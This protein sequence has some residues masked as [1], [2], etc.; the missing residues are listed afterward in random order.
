MTDLDIVVAATGCPNTLL[1]RV[2]WK[3]LMHRRKNR[4]LFLID[5][6]VPR[7][8]D[9]DVQSLDGVYLTISTIY[10]HSCAENVRSRQQAWPKCDQIID[11]VK[12]NAVQRLDVR[13][14]VARHSDVD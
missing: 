11:I 7:N 8:I 5:I 3:N 10:G 1:R 13:V 9:A 4:P 12:V 14:D 2:T 6:A